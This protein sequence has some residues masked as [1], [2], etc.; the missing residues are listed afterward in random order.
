VSSTVYH[1]TTRYEY[2]HTHHIACCRIVLSNHICTISTHC[3][4]CTAFSAVCT[5]FFIIPADCHYPRTLY[6]VS[7]ICT[8]SLLPR[9]LS[10]PGLYFL[11]TSL[12]VLFI[13]PAFIIPG[14]LSHCGL[15]ILSNPWTSHCV[16]SFYH[17]SDLHHIMIL[18]LCVHLLF[19]QLGFCAS[20]FI[21]EAPQTLLC[22]FQHFT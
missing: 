21:Y 4:L 10:I 3:T 17:L 8:A 14:P 22:M 18:S 13:V 12:C 19:T 6:S 9:R 15:T 7:C 2:Y 16:L 11:V 20:H 1:C 5:H